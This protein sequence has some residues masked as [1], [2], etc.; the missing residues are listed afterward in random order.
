MF[1]SESDNESLDED[2]DPRKEFER[3]GKSKPGRPA[4]KGRCKV[5][6][7][8]GPN[9]EASSPGPLGAPTARPALPVPASTSSVQ[10]ST[11]AVPALTSGPPSVPASISSS[12]QC[13][14]KKSPPA[15]CGFLA[16]FHKCLRILNQF[17]THVLH[18]PI[19]ARLQIFIQLSPTLT[20]LCHIKRDYL[21]HIICAKCPPSAE[22]YAF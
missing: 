2:Y 7:R 12:V 6:R 11:S 22:T 21:V 13:E 16:F 18:I 10:A 5:P 17:F 15:A 9:K 14:S 20:K 4:Q 3:R 8:A 1:Q 19:Y